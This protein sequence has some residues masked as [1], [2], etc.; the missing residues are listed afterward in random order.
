MKFITLRTSATGKKYIALREKMDV[1]IKE[2]ERLARKYK[3]KEWRSKNYT[4]AG[5][6]SAVIFKDK[7]NPDKKIWKFVNNS[8]NE[9]MP[10][11]NVKEG[12]LIGQ[13]FEAMPVVGIFEFSDAIKLKKFLCQPGVSWLNKKYI[14]ISIVDS[15]N[16]KMPSD[17]KEITVG[18]YEKIFK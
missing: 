12:K 3:L 6:F 5:G 16:H 14:G 8:R 18:E 4:V 10:K 2:Q 13:E 15:W 11:M 7:I 9:Y 17:C 1:A